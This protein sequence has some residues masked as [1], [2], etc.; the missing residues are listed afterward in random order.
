MAENRT[1]STVGVG[2]GAGS[3]GVFADGAIQAALYLAGQQPGYYT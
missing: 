1:V 3:R 2:S